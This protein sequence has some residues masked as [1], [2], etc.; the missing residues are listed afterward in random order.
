MAPPCVL[1]PPIKLLRRRLLSA[2]LEGVAA[3]AAFSVL[4]VPTVPMENSALP[5]LT[6]PPVPFPPPI[7]AV[8]L[9]DSTDATDAADDKNELDVLPALL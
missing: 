5:V 7:D 9:N 6:V 1:L 4:P 2:A 8:V 3:A